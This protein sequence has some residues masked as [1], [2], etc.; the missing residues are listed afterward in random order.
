VTNARHRL[1]ATL[2]A[3]ALALLVPVSAHAASWG[4]VGEAAPDYAAPT[5]D[6][7]DASLEDLRGEAV[8]LNVWATWCVPCRE[9]MPELQQLH[10]R[11]ADAGLRVVGVSVDDQGADDAVRGFLQ[12]EGVD[13]EV[14]RDPDRDVQRAFR[15]SGVPETILIDRDG[16][17]VER[18]KGPLEADDDLDAA[19]E[20][21][22]ESTGDYGVDSPPGSKDD[23]VLELGIAGLLLAMLAGLLSFLSPCVLPLLPAFL[24]VLTG[25]IPGGERQGTRN[26]AL[27][28][29][30]VF[31]AGFSSVFILLG[32]SASVIGGVLREWTDVI[33]LVGGVLLVLLGASLL[34]ILRI[35]LLQRDLRLHQRS[36]RT[37]R[38]SMFLVGVTFGAGWTP[39]IGPVLAGILTLAA[40]SASAW[41][42]VAL[43]GAY[44][45]GLGIPFVVSAVLV[46][47]IEPALRRSRRLMPWINRIA[48][49]LL[50]VFGLLLATG[51]WTRLNAWLIELAPGLARFG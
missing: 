42:G 12:D 28:T 2:A 17:V 35:P 7:D 1:A 33:T 36:E 47:R 29:S 4:E 38:A 45:L 44:S 46:D 16:I 27:L 10:E 22:L 20:R 30:L 25:T 5:L 24:A 6:G 31:V 13:Y 15:T 51:T 23:D 26:A 14:W 49:V 48:G 37:G 32:A 40:A 21:A 39:C 34:G 9:E 3:V 50:I 43:L 8:L 19:V 11:H 18:W 41:H